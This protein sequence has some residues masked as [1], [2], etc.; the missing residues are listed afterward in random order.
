MI[1]VFVDPGY[2]PPIPCGPCYKKVSTPPGISLDKAD[3][4]LLSIV[5]KAG[6][7][8]IRIWEP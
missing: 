1:G 4:A 3:L 7:Y 5:E 6:V 8:G 2:R